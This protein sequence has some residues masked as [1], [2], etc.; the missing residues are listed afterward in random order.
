VAQQPRPS[1]RLDVAATGIRIGQVLEMQGNLEGALERF[2]TA[3]DMK[4]ELEKEA[5][6]GSKLIQS[7]LAT[8][9]QSNLATN[10]RYIAQAYVQ[11]YDRDASVNDLDSAL[12]E[13]ETAIKIHERL[14]DNDSGNASWQLSLASSRIGLAE[15]LRKK[16]ELGAALKQARYAYGLRETLAHKD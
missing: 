11:R 1:W 13:Y 8:T 10:H 9:I 2:R 3:L 5:A 12:D 7:D 16:E 15:V 14:R 6:S 4:L